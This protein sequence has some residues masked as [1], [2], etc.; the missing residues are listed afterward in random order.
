MAVSLVILDHYAPFRTLA[1]GA[2]ARH[3]GLG[4]DIFF[5]LSGFLIT[6]ILLESRTQSHPYRVFYARRSMRILPAYALLLIFVYS[7]GAWLREPLHMKT[8][9]GQLLFL[10]SFLGTGTLLHQCI[11]VMQHPSSLPGLLRIIPPLV[12]Q[13]DYGHLPMAASLGPTWSLSV[14]EWFYFLWAPVVLLLSR[15]AI[16]I[17]AVAIC[18]MGISLRCLPGAGTSFLT[19]VDIL[20]SGALLALWIEKRPKLAPAVR[21]HVDRSIAAVSALAMIALV[22][23]SW[24]HRD[25]L[26]RTLIEISVMG[27]LAWLFRHS[28]ESHP[29]AKVLRCRPLV[30]LGSISY[31]IYLIHLPLYFIARH[32]VEPR[33]IGIAPLQRM[34]AVALC[35]LAATLLFATASWF[36]LEKPLLNQKE[37]MTA[38]LAA[39]QR[40]GLRTR[41]TAGERPE[42][43]STS[44]FLNPAE[45]AASSHSGSLA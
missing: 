25:G 28:G 4:V 9:L 24:S 34:W 18:G 38:W 41:Q 7:V 26:S 6:T 10:R 20:V 44:L 43:P 21:L 19:S 30:Y 42:T 31:M 23:L 5:V 32:I 16:A 15:R 33:A 35:S 17:T 14:E 8:L 40:K 11:H 3:G 13:A 37:R 2:A 12:V 22:V 36:F 39:S 1:H 45:D 27:A 29:V